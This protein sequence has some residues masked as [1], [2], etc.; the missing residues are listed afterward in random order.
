MAQIAFAPNGDRSLKKL[1]QQSILNNK[2]FYCDLGVVENPFSKICKWPKQKTLKI[3]NL[4][5]TQIS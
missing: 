4:K 5:I 3:F 2:K 1:T